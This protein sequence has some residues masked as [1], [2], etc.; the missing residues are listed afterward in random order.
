MNFGVNF[1]VRFSV[2]T[3]R[4]KITLNLLSDPEKPTWSLGF[5]AEF[6]NIELPGTFHRRIA[7]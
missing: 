3:P 2:I 6:F 1:S 5:L 4:L 7:L